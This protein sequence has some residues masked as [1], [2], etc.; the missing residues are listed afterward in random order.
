M[1]KLFYLKFGKSSRRK[2]INC[3]LNLQAIQK[4]LV[5]MSMKHS[6]CSLALDTILMK[7]SSFFD[8]YGV[9]SIDGTLINGLTIF[10]VIQA[11]FYPIRSKEL[12]GF[13]QFISML[14]SLNLQSYIENKDFQ[15]LVLDDLWFFLGPAV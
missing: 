12:P 10:D 6:F 7:L 1:K 13:S 5:M 8:R 3:C 9:I 11:T 15:D 2:L 14:K 4:L